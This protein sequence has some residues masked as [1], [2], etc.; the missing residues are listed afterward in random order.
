MAQAEYIT[1]FFS[2]AN[3]L[4][5]QLVKENLSLKKPGFILDD[6]ALKQRDILI[7][8]YETYA[9][10]IG[11]NEQ[12]LRD[13]DPETKALALD[14]GN[15]IRELVSENVLRLRARFE[16]NL[17]LIEAFTDAVAKKSDRLET[18]TKKG[19]TRSAHGAAR[20]RTIAATFDQTL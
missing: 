5:A 13:L 16:A 4:E 17:Q 18:Y 2:I 11:E 20:H 3:D 7:R 12:D 15:R 14:I 1:R 10:E 9:R 6:D 8:A 19:A